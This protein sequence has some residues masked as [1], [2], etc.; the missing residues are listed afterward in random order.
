MGYFQQHLKVYDREG[1]A[2][3]VCGT[4]VKRIVQV[5]RSSYFCPRCQKRR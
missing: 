3:E 4:R 5:G 1:E 2:C